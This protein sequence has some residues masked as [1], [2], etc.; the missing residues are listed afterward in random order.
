MRP[1]PHL[2]CVLVAL[3]LAGTA[4]ADPLAELSDSVTDLFSRWRNSRPGRAPRWRKSPRPPARSP[5][6]PC[7]RRARSIC[8]R[9][10]NYRGRRG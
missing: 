10:S 7:A 2:F 5:T 8:G 1:A 3:G 6:A 4:H 9:C